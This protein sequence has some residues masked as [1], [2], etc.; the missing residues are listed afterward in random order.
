MEVEGT[1][2]EG[3]HAGDV[4]LVAFAGTEYEVTCPDG[5]AALA[6][7]LS[8]AACMLCSLQ[9]GA[10]AVGDEGVGVLCKA[11]ERNT[12]L[13]SLGLRGPIYF[14][15]IEESLSLGLPDLNCVIYNPGVAADIAR[16]AFGARFCRKKARREV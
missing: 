5:A 16:A 8:D 9:L 15:Y 2:P 4:F 11:L 6:R 14:R 7:C 1:V 13:T 3:C 10:N 12:T